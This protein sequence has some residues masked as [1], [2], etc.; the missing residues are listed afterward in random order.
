[1]LA[2][3]LVVVVVCVLTVSTCRVASGT[4]TDRPG[5]PPSAPPPSAWDSAAAAFLA[6]VFAERWGDA[7]AGTSGAYR[8]MVSPDEFASIAAKN[9]YFRPGAK[10]DDRGFRSNAYPHDVAK[11]EGILRSPAGEAWTTV[12]LCLEEGRWLVTGVLLGGQPGLP[13]PLVPAASHKAPPN[14]R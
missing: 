13:Q 10:F 7:Y 8:E 6:D 14:K 4:D 11:V 3:G 1:M 2:R 12:Y 5:P 9:P